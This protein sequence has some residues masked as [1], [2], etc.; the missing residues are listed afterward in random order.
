MKKTKKIISLIIILSIITSAFISL[1]N[2]N[3]VK[4][5]SQSINEDIN[6]IDISKYPGIK[7]K[8]QELQAKYPEWKFKLLY[9]G[10]DWNEAITNEYKGHGSSPKNLVYKSTNY[11]GEWI[12]AICG[13]KS[14]DNGSWRCASEQA[15]KYMMD[16]RNSLN[17]TD[18]FQFEELTNAE[19]NIDTLKTMVEGTFLENHEQG[20][21]D[22]A[23]NNNINAYY[24]VARLIQEQGISGTVLTSGTGYNNQY[25]GYY[26]AFNIAAS[27]NSTEEILNNALAYAT[28]KEWTTLEKSIDGGI[29]FLAKQYIQKGQNTLYLQKFDVEATDGLYSNQY[30]QNILAAQKEGETLRSTYIKI[31][32]LSSSHTF[33]IPIYENMPQEICSRPDANKINTTNEDIVKVNVE[34]SLRIRNNPNGDTTIGYLYPN[35]I[36]TRLEKATSKVNGTY[37]DKIRKS[38]GTEGYAARETFENEEKYKLYLEP[39]NEEQSSEDQNQESEDN[40]NQIPEFTI[41]NTEKVK[42]DKENKTIMVTP[43][44]I[45]NDILETCGGIAKITRADE[46]FLDGSQELLG[47]GYIVED[48]YIVIKKGD[49]N[50]DGNVDISDLLALQK[51]LLGVNNISNS[52]KGIAADIVNDGDLDISDLL[53]MQKYLLGISNIDI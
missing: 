24:I 17:E 19:S 40:S 2:C 21:L 6:S 8:I 43:D 1:I 41:I 12:C 32:S 34:G 44:A 45:A 28:K 31:N 27:G 46:N 29:S 47:T 49:C 3:Q 37:W 14:Y 50:G 4:A 5:I 15:I 53:K 38:D 10:L 48:E 36:V 11:Q 42:F 33:I 7:E 30:M 25:Q 52:P 51:H 16:P 18:I 13:D 35:E 23:N 22:A 9:T 39:L 26:N 20:I